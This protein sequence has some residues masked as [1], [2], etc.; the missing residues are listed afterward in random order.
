[1]NGFL[2]GY[3]TMDALAA[4]A[5]GVTVVTAVRGLGLK[6][7][8]DVAKSTAKAGVMATSWIG[9]IYVALILLGSMSLAHFK[10]SPE[11]GTAF[12]QVVTYYFWRCW[13]CGSGNI[14]DVDLPHHCSWLGCCVC[15]RFPSSFP[16]GQLSCLVGTDQF[17]I[18]LNG[19]LW[20]GANHRLVCPDA[21][22]SSILSQWY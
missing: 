2:Q 17:S 10:L 18:L 7:D 14:V 12:N 9:L 13:S 15:A 22:A 20:F 4:L 8:D 5:F 19:E 11:G 6:N 21:D 16:K 1:M 3:N